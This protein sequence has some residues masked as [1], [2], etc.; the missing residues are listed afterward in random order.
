MGKLKLDFSYDYDFFLVSIHST[1]EDYLLAFRLNAVFNIQF[2]KSDFTLSFEKKKGEFSVFDFESKENFTFWSLIS[3]KQTVEENLENIS[4]SLFDSVY[5]TYI[6]LKEKKDIDY[7]LKI[8]GDFTAQQKKE[9]ITKIN[10]INGV[11]ACIEL[12]PRKI[13]TINNLIY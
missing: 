8:E 12:Q 5:N 11:L 3:N 4:F 10:T 7:F 1:L 13:K 9:I 2:R 6:L